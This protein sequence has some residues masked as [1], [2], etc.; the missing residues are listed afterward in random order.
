MCLRFAFSLSCK[1]HNFSDV[2]DLAFHVL[3]MQ[4]DKGKPLHQRYWVKV[5]PCSWIS[6]SAKVLQ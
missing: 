4:A 3:H 1:G 2:D 6:T 5:R